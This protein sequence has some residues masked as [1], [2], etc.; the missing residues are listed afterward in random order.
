M[1]L[2]SFEQGKL[3]REYKGH[4]NVKYCIKSLILDKWILSGT[5]TG[6]LYFWDLDST[7]LIESVAIGTSPI[8]GM[9]WE[10]KSHY[11]AL[12]CMEDLTLKI[13]KL[14]F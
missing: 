13:Y 3:V 12:S 11:L 2:W 1:K 8:L 5:E 10:S 9:S 4:L 6:Y 14:S 7:E